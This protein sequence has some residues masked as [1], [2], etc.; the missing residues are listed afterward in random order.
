M[1]DRARQL[2]AEKKLSNCEFRLAGITDLSFLKDHSVDAV[3]STLAFHHLPDTASLQQSFREARRILK[4]AAEFISKPTW[5]ICAP[6]NRS[7][8]SDVST[9]TVSPRC[10]RS[11]ILTPLRAAFS[12]QDFRDAAQAFGEQVSVLSTFLVP[13]M[14]GQKR[15]APSFRPNAGQRAT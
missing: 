1:L 5:V 14:V 15:H 4:P 12:L 9:R 8:T 7:S 10:L 2:A 6:R 13:Y 11:T 3:S